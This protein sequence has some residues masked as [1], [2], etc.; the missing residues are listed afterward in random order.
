MNGKFN[1]LCIVL[2][3]MLVSAMPSF[4]ACQASIEG[5]W[6]VYFTPSDGSPPFYCNVSLVE[7]SSGFTSDLANCLSTSTHTYSIQSATLSCLEDNTNYY[8]G[9]IVLTVDGS[10]ST[11]SVQG[12]LNQNA[13]M[14]VAM[15]TNTVAPYYT[16]QFVMD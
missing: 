4:A 3:I 14:F 11:V 9:Q 8:G 1:R 2:G 7:G 15:S 10:S 5:D 6:D 13:N 12:T 16:L